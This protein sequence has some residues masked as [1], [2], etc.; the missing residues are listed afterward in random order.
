MNDVIEPQPSANIRAL[1]DQLMDLRHKIVAAEL[2]TLD[3]FGVAAGVKPELTNLAHYLALRRYD[4]RG[5]QRAMMWRGL[6]SLGR[7][8]GRV[9]PTLNAVLNAVAAIQA[10][11]CPYP[12]PSEAEFFAGEAM[13]SAATDALFG[14]PPAHRRGRIMVTLPSEAATEPGFVLDLAQ[15]GMDIARI[16]CAHDDSQAWRAMADNVRAAGAILGRRLAVLMDIA[17]PKIRTGAVRLAEKK[18]K[19]HTGDAFRLVAE[20]EPHTDHSVKFCAAVSLPEMVNR[21]SVGDR[22]LYDDGKLEG[23]VESTV[24]GE[25]IV[26]VTKA[27]ANGANLKP[28]KGI[29]LPDTALGLSPLTAKDERDLTTVISCADI[30]GYSFV[31]RPQDLDILEEALSR[32]EATGRRL[33]LIAK[34]ETP[35]AVK[36]LPALIARASGRRAFGVMI[37]RGDLAAEIGFERLAEMQEEILWICEAASTPAIWA[38]QVLENLVS[39][40]VPSRGEMTDAAMAARAECVMLNKGPAIGTAVELLDRLLARMDGHLHKKTAMLRE[41]RSW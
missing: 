6:S 8:E 5:L 23:V 29:N 20:G 27:K 16:N 25:A 32:H 31:S 3:G 24:A 37:A 1:Y 41:L 2:E 36:N 34:I 18:G 39:T 21:L 33:G 26:R 17:G 28:E 7:L 38:T 10:T 35:E 9:L 11:D 14:P 12:A 15:R 13:L 40:G 19:L 22:V 4:L 30:I